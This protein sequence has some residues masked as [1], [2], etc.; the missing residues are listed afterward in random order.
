LSSTIAK[1]LPLLEE[2]RLLI[3]HAKGQGV[4]LIDLAA[5]T[6]SPIRS[7]EELTE[8]TFDPNPKRLRL[9]VGPSGQSY[10]SWLDLQTGD[11]QEV[12][13]DAPIGQM[14]PM[15]SVG[16]IAILHDNDVGHITVI[17]AVKPERAT[18]RSA[19]GFLISGLLD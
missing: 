7:S 14:V 17:D 10:V 4:S 5:R 8:A 12:L 1:V 6:V 9:W 2:G 3:L 15:L 16:K 19:R 18:A 13:L 11:T